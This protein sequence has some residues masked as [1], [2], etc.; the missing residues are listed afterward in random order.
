MEENISLLIVD[1]DDTFR[2]ILCQE[3]SMK[4]YKAKGASNGQEAIAKVKERDFDVVLLDIKMPDMGGIE[5]LEII[6]EIVSSTEVIMLTG[7]GTIENAIQ[8]MKLGAYD[9]ITKPFELDHLD[10]VIKKAYDK[11]NLIHENYILKQELSKMA[12]FP[13]FVGESPGMR[14]VFGLIDKVSKT[15][16]T[17]LIQGESGVGKELV[18]RA[19]HQ[20]S[21]RRDNPFVVIDC[22]S[23]Q[24]SLLENELFGHEKGAYTGADSW[25]HGLFEVANQGT[26]FMDEIAE[27]SP[28]IQAKLLRVLETG[29]F[30]RIGGTKDIKVDVRVITA[31]NQNLDKMVSKGRFREDLFY[32][33][34]IIS[35]S[36]PPLR[37]RQEDIPLLI[38]YFMKHTTVTRKRK[39]ITKEAM[40]LLLKYHWPGNI[41]ELRNVIERALI[42]S[43]DSFIHP[44]DLPANLKNPFNSLDSPKDF[45]PLRELEKEYIVKV[46]KACK[47]HRKKMAKL[48]GISERNLYRKLK[49]CM[50]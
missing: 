34:N 36:V 48:L 10:I 15:D 11:K 12:T 50:K 17:V 42:L 14:E 1:D 9:F 3:L 37:E 23:L 39:G 43:E 32:R 28:A 20:N 29:T 13:D 5:T 41:R 16:L 25:K 33:L 27:I 31:T 22:T 26:L 4:G 30:R 44:Q 46:F 45:I 6:K 18:A 40:E 49:N 35:I 38:N 24:E 47:G 7:H 19:I 2:E 21:E 8:S